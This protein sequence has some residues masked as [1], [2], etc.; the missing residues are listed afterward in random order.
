MTQN[1]SPCH[2]L[3]LEKQGLKVSSSK[4]LRK[5]QKFRGIPRL[6]LE[7]AKEK[8]KIPRLISSSTLE[9]FYQRSRPCPCQMTPR[10]PLAKSAW[11]QLDATFTKYL[12]SYLGIPKHS[13]NAIVHHLC[14]TI[15]F[16]VYISL[17]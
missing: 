14:E 15:P 7:K 11:D 13:N 12:K 17:E 1:S 9:K 6:I 8:G 5:R 10:E 4:W 2:V 3:D 16:S